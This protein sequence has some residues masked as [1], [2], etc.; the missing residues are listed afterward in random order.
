MFP[1]FLKLPNS[2]HPRLHALHGRDRT[3]LLEDGAELAYGEGPA[4]AGA[5]PGPNGAGAGAGGGG[6]RN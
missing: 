5:A 2:K 4:A 6:G 1:K 3:G